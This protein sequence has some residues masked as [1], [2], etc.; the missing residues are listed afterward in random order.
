[1][2]LADWW[3]GESIFQHDGTNYTRRRIILSVAE[4][5]GG[6]HVDEDLE[7]Y[8]KVLLAGEYAIGITGDMTYDGPPP[9]PQ[10]VTIYPDNAHLALIRQFA[11]E[12]LASHRHFKWPVL[13]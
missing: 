1:M 12:V 4:K 9:F 6:T 13:K 3:D 11:H 8:Y 5:D 7:P 10:G 2:P